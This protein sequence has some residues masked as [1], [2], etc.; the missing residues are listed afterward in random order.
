M[1]EFEFNDEDFDEEELNPNELNVLCITEHKSV[2]HF[3]KGNLYSYKKL[4]GSF[5]SGDGG[6]RHGYDYSIVDENGTVFTIQIN[7]PYY[8]LF[9]WE[10]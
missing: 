10:K 7:S 4:S 2:A 5:L 3:T 1:K 8:N 9:K 6:M